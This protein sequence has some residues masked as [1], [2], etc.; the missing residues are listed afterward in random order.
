MQQW[1]G[2]TPLREET[3]SRSGPREKDKYRKLSAT[4]SPLRFDLSEVTQ[5]QIKCSSKA[6]FKDVD[7]VFFHIGRMKYYLRCRRMLVVNGGRLQI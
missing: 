5:L 6:D 3:W 7:K 1:T 4:N 2:K